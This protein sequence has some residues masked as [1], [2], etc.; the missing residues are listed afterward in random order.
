M[1]TVTLAREL[2]RLQ[3]ELLVLADQAQQALLVSVDTLKRRDLAGAQQLIALEQQIKKKR[4]AI[5]MDCLTLIVTQQPGDGYVRTISAILEMATELERIGA[6]AGD[7]ARIPFMVVEPPVLELL[8][9]M[10]RMATA[11]QARL[12]R[13]M[14]AFVN[15]E[16]AQGQ[17]SAA[18]ANQ[19][20]ALYS[21]LYQD[22]LTLL[23][24]SSRKNGS[25]TTVNQVRY[26]SRVA[27]NLK[28]AADRAARIGEW[29]AL[30]FE[31]GTP[32]ERM[33]QAG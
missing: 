24:N 27:R 15:K 28:G 21:K 5:E 26:L 12:R 18:E 29:A 17:A 10:Q 6:C 19:V 8:P 31:A 1:S 16:A 3:D 4:F 30:A 22:L 7:N 9:D 32:I 11:I 2:S 33:P 20:D 13:G 14:Q 25:R 23:K